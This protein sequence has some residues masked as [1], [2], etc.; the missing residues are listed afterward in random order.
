MRRASCVVGLK[1][2]R[3]KRKP[4]VGPSVPPALNLVGDSSCTS[5]AARCRS[6]RQP[7]RPKADSSCRMPRRCM[8]IRTTAT[9]SAPSSLI[10][11]S[12]QVLLSAAFEPVIGHLKDDHRMRRNY[13]K[14]RD[15]DRTNAV[16]AAAGYNIEQRL[17]QFCSTQSGSH[18]Y[19]GPAAVARCWR[20]EF[21]IVFAILTS[22]VGEGFVKFGAAGAAMSPDCRWWRPI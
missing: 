13:L 15:G 12:S 9:R 14:G 18:R 7:P 4:N 11:T 3:A 22:P 2:S 16:H 5:S 1:S 10:S 17:L 21:P 6:P 20:P 19:C 8:A